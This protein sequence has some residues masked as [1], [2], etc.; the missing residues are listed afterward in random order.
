MKVYQKLKVPDDLHYCPL[1]AESSQVSPK[2]L[3]SY[4]TSPYPSICHIFKL[5][6][7]G[8]TQVT[9]LSPFL[10]VAYNINP[11]LLVYRLVTGNDDKV[12]TPV[13]YYPGIVHNG[14]CLHTECLTVNV[15]LPKTK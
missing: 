10:T 4:V 6:R 11:F 3:N 14:L 5:Y 8:F 13:R 9:L 7:I 1:L 12:E 2:Q 15:L